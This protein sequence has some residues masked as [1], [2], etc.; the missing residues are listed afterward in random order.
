MSYRDWTLRSFGL[1]GRMLHKEHVCG[2][3]GFSVSPAR[4]TSLSLFFIFGRAQILPSVLNVH[5]IVGIQDYIFFRVLKKAGI[6][7]DKSCFK[8]LINRA[9][10]ILALPMCCFLSGDHEPKPQTYRVTFVETYR[11][12]V[13]GKGDMGTSVSQ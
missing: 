8:F 3:T 2:Y 9:L 1:A 12:G 4:L 11:L 7:G 6:S 10:I 13:S 5:T